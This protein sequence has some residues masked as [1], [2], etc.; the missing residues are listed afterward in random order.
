MRTLEF[1]TTF[2]FFRS[3]DD[4]NDEKYPCEK[5]M[6]N[7][8]NF[9]DNFRQTAKSTRDLSYIFVLFRHPIDTPVSRC[10]RML[11]LTRFVSPR[12]ELIKSFRRK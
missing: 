7:F 11:I 10:T 8:S 12:Y 2:E 1:S 3:L 5:T 9:Y 4:L 6:L